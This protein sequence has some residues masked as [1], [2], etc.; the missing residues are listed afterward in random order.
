MQASQQT[1]PEHDLQLVDLGNAKELTLG[2]PVGLVPEDNPLY[3]S[4]MEG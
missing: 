1:Q 3:P 2:P 4:R